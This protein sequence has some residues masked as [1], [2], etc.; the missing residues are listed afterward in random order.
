VHL[1]Y[2]GRVEEA[3]RAQRHDSRRGKMLR[4]MEEYF[5][6]SDASAP[7]SV[8]KMKK[9]KKGK[10]D[11]PETVQIP[12]EDLK[13]PRCKG[14]RDDRRPPRDRPLP[15][16]LQGAEARAGRNLYIS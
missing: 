8:R 2:V 5:D 16:A 7:R 6:S 15:R 10:K 13:C 14:F 11:E 1:H 9:P 4:K 3:E 12:Y